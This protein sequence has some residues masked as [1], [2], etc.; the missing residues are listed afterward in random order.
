M[1]ASLVGSEMCIRDSPPPFRSRA[2]ALCPT[3]ACARP[4]VW[5]MGDRNHSPVPWP[6]AQPEALESQPRAPVP[7]CSPGTHSDFRVFC[8][9]SP[10]HRTRP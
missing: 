2:L 8:I 5:A 4:G 6:P 1:S 10:T 7:E 3:P 9:M